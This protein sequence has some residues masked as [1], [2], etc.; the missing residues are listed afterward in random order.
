MPQSPEEFADVLPT[1]SNF[2]TNVREVIKESGEI[3]VIFFANILF[4]LAPQ[5]KDLSFDGTF[6]VVPKIFM[7]LFTLM[8]VVNNHSFPL[9]FVL[10][11]AKTQVLY[12][13]V[14]STVRD[15]FPELLPD[16][17][18]GDFELA[19]RN[20]LELH[21]PTATLGG[22]QFH[23]SQSLWKKIQ[24]LGLS[25]LYMTNKDFQKYV[26]TT[27]SLP[28]LPSSEIQSASE[29]LSLIHF[30]TSPVNMT[31]I[32]KF[33]KYIRTYWLNTVT[34]EKLSVFNFVRGT[35]NDCE[36]YHSQLKARIK[37]HRPN[38][39][40]FLGHINNLIE[41]VSLDIERLHNGLQIARPQKPSVAKALQHR[42]TCKQKL[43]D[44]SYTPMKFLAAISHTFNTTAFQNLPSDEDLS[45]DSDDAQ[46]QGERRCPICHGSCDP[47]YVLV[48][49]GHTYCD[50]CS[51]LLLGREDPCG[52][53][54]APINSR[55]RAFL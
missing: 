7:Q 31:Q 42:R 40:S 16:F 51:Q 47:A 33:R 9:I 44:G 53:C 25:K 39:W 3:A 26:R 18:M 24:K 19:S 48:P 45:E 11:T 21:F 28:Y 17:L 52:L 55:V 13:A 27:M 8:A 36:A 15:F 49:C 50:N 10:M 2:N 46:D 4:T 32:K 1:A 6:F 34:P 38:P 35:N 29:Q 54:R 22:C 30:D 41:D 37:T 5:L 23:F 14:I 12:E 20:A 43:L